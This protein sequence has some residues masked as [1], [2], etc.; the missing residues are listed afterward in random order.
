M[1]NPRLNSNDG[2]LMCMDYLN[3]S[4]HNL[5]RASELITENNTKGKQFDYANCPELGHAVDRLESLVKTISDK[6]YQK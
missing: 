1:K 5:E 4:I 6:V 3:Q 2:T